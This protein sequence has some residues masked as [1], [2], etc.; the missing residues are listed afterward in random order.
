MRSSRPD[1]ALAL[2]LLA[3]VPAAAR[4]QH[5]DSLVTRVGAMSAVTGLEDAMADTL[6]TLL[7]GARKDRAGNVI[8]VRGTGEPVRLAACPMDEIGYVVG[9]ITEDGYLALRRVGGTNV[10]PLYDQFLEGHRVTVFGRNRAVPGVVGVKSTHLTRGRAGGDDPVFA[11]DNAWVDVGAASAREVAALGIQVLAPVTRAKSV[12]RYG[13]QGALFAAPWIAQRAACAAL[14]SAALRASTGPGTT[15]IAF[16]A[17]RHFNNDGL[18]FV[19]SSYPSAAVLTL[20]GTAT[21]AMGTGPANASDTI[22]GRAAAS[23]TLPVRYARTPAETV[24]LADVTQLEQRI[25]GWLGG[26]R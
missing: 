7:P 21:T 24:G 4:A 23:W 13:A 5:L 19:L 9:S 2:L 25:I 10:G 20:G 12:H 1:A 8:Q 14:L 6:V 15:V 17:R 3:A 18:Q 22:A 11:L 16:T 26:A